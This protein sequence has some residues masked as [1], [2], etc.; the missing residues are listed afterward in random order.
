MGPRRTERRGRLFARRHYL[1][2]L[3][4]ITVSAGAGAGA[5]RAAGTISG[6]VTQ[7]AE[8]SPVAG[9]LV[10]VAAPDQPPLSATT[11]ADG[12]F[13]IDVGG[14]GPFSVGVQ[15]GGF[16]AE[17][18]EGVQPGDPVAFSLAPATYTP[19]P[20]NGGSGSAVVADARS[21]IFYLLA[22]GAP[23]VYRSLDHGGSWH[24]VTPS[25]D[26]QDTGLSNSAD[27]S[28][29]AA[30]GVSGELAVGA[31][32]VCESG[33]VRHPA[34]YSTDYGLTWKQI[35]GAT[36][37]GPC[38]HASRELFW[39]HAGPGAPNVLMAAVREQDGSW[40]VWRA[41]MSAANP[42]FV[43]E[44]SDPF[45]S[46]S[47]ID[48]AD[49]ANGS[50]IG[51]LSASGGLSFAPLTASGPIEFGA[52]Q[53]SGLPSPPQLLRLGGAEEA[54]APPD[55]LLAVG[56]TSPV[57]GVMLTKAAG[58]ASFEG[59]SAS[60]PTELAGC[61]GAGNVAPVS[62]GSVAPTSTGNSGTG[63]S[64][65]CWV[66][67]SGTGNPLTLSPGTSTNLRADDDMAYDAGYG[68][69]AN[70]VSL[71]A[72]G[73]QG[74]RKYARLNAEG[75][76]DGQIEVLAPAGADPGS[77]GISLRGITSPPVQDM[78]YGPGGAQEVAVAADNLEIASKDGGRTMTE[79]VSR[80]ASGGRPAGPGARVVEWWQGASGEWLVY[81]GSAG[82]FNSGNMLTA[83]LDWDGA[84]TLPSPNVAATSSADFGGPPEGYWG[85]GDFGLNALTPVPGTDT[86]FVALVTRGEDKYGSGNHLYRATIQPGNPP[87]LSGLAN[88]DPPAGGPTLNPPQAMAYCPE[89]EATHPG[90]RDVLFVAASRGGFGTGADM[91]SLLRFADATGTPSASVVE[92][93]PHDAEWTGLAD[94]RAD[95]DAGVVYTGGTTGSPNASSLYK[96]I[97]GG[98]TF[99]R[100]AV[101]WKGTQPFGFVNA[102]GLNPADPD[103]VTL[104]GVGS[105]RQVHSADGGATWTIVN[106]PEVSRPSVVNDIEYLP[107]AA[108]A[109][110]SSRAA[111]TPAVRIAASSASLAAVGTSS[112]AFL[113]DVSAATGL[114]GQS[115]SGGSPGAVVR[116]TSLG[117]DDHPSIA[118]ASPAG[119]ST[120]TV[121]RRGDGLYGTSAVAG[122]WS[123]PEQI[124]GTIAGDD[125]PAA[126][127]D[128]SG[129]LHVAFAR[130]GAAPGIYVTT[131]AN[132]A[133]SAPQRISKKAGD[134]LPAIAVTQ[135]KRVQ[136][137]V[138]FLRTSGRTRGVFRA[139]DTGGS[140]RKA[141]K[142]EGTR[143]LDARTALGGPT[144][145]ASGSD[146]H[147]AFA[148]GGKRAGVYYAKGRGGK[149]GRLA[150]LTDVRGDAQ[151]A[152]AV[153]P[154]DR[155]IV[156][157]RVR[158]HRRGLLEVR[159]GR[160]WKLRQIPGTVAQDADPALYRTPS[161]L[162]VAFARPAGESPGIYYDTR[163]GSGGWLTQ[164][165]RWSGDAVDRD[166]AIAAGPK[167]VT[168]VFDRG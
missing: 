86:I 60:A 40:N 168:I 9:A 44:A 110:A 73:T 45:G 137:H 5:A 92:S 75:V 95:C 35:P 163:Y 16:A 161:A 93:V 72:R 155:V 158:G 132:G 90:M 113:G 50:F 116:I 104:A 2:A 120:V 148:R 49:S 157:R 118:S 141:S 39:A 131:L 127:L 100:I 43:R 76:P 48:V 105:G 58:S 19:L 159:A 62:G 25:Y 24:P 146:V 140:W 149:W 17:S 165:Q 121:F 33:S 134:T 21:G 32:A 67:K 91:G 99:E 14:A 15:A 57:M 12:G 7:L 82:L 143:G 119:G 153:D 61:R 65:R 26:D 51:R 41:D 151:P 152:I 34:S 167:D 56:G 114:M 115:A 112:G 160:R 22:A 150:R 103:D 96:S 85:T 139:A 70:V 89:S 36:Y 87:S 84:S 13:A 128:A 162:F 129:I 29:I 11:G 77:G 154:A 63:N 142:V 156:F 109:S 164:P 166:P 98:Q 126:A 97:D 20:V 94:V 138:A 68:Q 54:D 69:G 42:Q 102:I 101:P 27:D 79:V 23:E 145:A 10:T 64:D 74:P 80:T 18:V 6:S 147:L 108:P 81:G 47:E 8:G 130:T 111:Q 37:P 133:W 83:V 46:G 55:G 123:M 66:Q 135:G 38:S 59:A 124:A 71:Q 125:F 144:L 3:F 117:S 88:I 4:A 52:E 78:D 122:A 28:A 107:G 1:L 30:S 53:V 106:D 31:S 136:T